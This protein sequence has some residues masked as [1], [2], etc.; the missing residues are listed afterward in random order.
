MLPV[1]GASSVQTICKLRV[2][3]GVQVASFFDVPDR[4]LEYDKSASGLS[5][6]SATFTRCFRT[7]HPHR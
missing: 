3:G 1:G 5:R 4:R 7:S 2:F 6:I